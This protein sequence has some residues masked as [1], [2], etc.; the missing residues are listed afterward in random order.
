MEKILPTFS[1]QVRKTCPV[2]FFFFNLVSD[3]IC[4]FTMETVQDIKWISKLIE[5]E[6]LAFQLQLKDAVSTHF[7]TSISAINFMSPPHLRHSLLVFPPSY[8]DSQ[9]PVSV[10]ARLPLFFKIMREGLVTF[11]ILRT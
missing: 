11:S 9:T 6:E 7:I 5:V 3:F 10:W 2:W 1:L 4:P 8:R